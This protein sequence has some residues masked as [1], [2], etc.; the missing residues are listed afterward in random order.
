LRR[1]VGG[2]GQII[3]A[4]D[5]ASG[6]RVCSYVPH[7][8]LH[9]RGIFAGTIHRGDHELAWRADHQ[10]G[11][12]FTLSDDGAELARFAA[13]SASRP[14]TASI[15]EVDRVEPLLLLFCCHLAKQAVDT[16]RV[17]AAAAVGVA[18]GA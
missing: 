3:R 1:A 9:L 13:G 11:H 12:R 2:I 10:L 18:A 6:E 14:V 5:N 7:G 8:V 4:R 16:A 15:G 17:G